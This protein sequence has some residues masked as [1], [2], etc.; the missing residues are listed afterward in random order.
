MWVL[1]EKR[2]IPSSCCIHMPAQGDR[3]QKHK[4]P[5]DHV[6]KVHRLLEIPKETWLWRYLV[7][8]GSPL[9]PQ[10]IVHQHPGDRVCPSTSSRPLEGPDT[11]R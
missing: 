2:H 8:C 10:P 1:E 3:S 9:L 11:E 4:A 5:G 7:R 6:V